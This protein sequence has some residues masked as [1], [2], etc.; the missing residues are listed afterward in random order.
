MRLQDWKWAMLPALA[1]CASSA[2]AYDPI[3]SRQGWERVDFT[4]SGPCEAEVGTNG[5]FYV[6][7]VYGMEPG[8]QADF[9]LSNGDMQP[10][11]RS[12]H[13]DGEGVWTNYYIPFRWGRSGGTVDAR[14]SSESCDIA[15]SFD[16]TRFRG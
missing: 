2:A 11:Q 14:V 7:A 9:T 13:A 6:I 8:E 3:V 12:V 10:I 1:L 5:R 15:L 4:R 16:W